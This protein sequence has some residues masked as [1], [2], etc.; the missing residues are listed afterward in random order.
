V[1]A[2]LA[3][4]PGMT[5]EKVARNPDLLDK[6]LEQ[7]Q[8]EA[9]AVA[10][11]GTQPVQMSAEERKH[12]TDAYT[13]AEIF[14]E[15]EKEIVRDPRGWGG[16]FGMSARVDNI[17]ANFN[18][19][20]GDRAMQRAALEGAA[21]MIRKATSGTALSLYEIKYVQWLPD[22]REN[23]Q[24]ILAKLQA[25]RINILKALNYG[26]LVREGKIEDME[27]NFPLLRTGTGADIEITKAPSSRQ[28]I[29]GRTQSQ[30]DAD[31]EAA[32]LNIIPR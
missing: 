12:F 10:K 13:A 20:Q 27:K 25:T 3:A 8:L 14:Y 26:R 28:P 18:L 2:R 5:P 16:P 23:H 17:L 11:A 9:K 7:I 21:S 4:T 19:S 29:G 1:A 15:I 22:W 31:D 24:Q 30:Q 6:A 32:R